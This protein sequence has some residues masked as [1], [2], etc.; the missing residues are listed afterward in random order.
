MQT[1]TLFPPILL[2]LNFDQ[3]PSLF[4]R[5]VLLS[6]VLL[7]Y[8]L[9][10]R[11]DDNITSRIKFWR[12]NVRR[13]INI[14]Q[15][16][17]RFHALHRTANGETLV[18]LQSL[19]ASLDHLLLIELPLI[20]G[21]LLI[22]SVAASITDRDKLSV[23]EL[24]RGAQKSFSNL[25]YG[26]IFLRH[27]LLAIHVQRI[28]SREITLHLLLLRILVK[29]SRWWASC[30]SCFKICDRGRKI[31]PFCGLILPK[32]PPTLIVHHWADR[33]EYVTFALL[34]F[35]GCL[36]QMSI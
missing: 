18:I 32:I 13:S 30:L 27:A 15:R 11:N 35:W 19:W 16:R 23:C 26:L 24:G 8:L 1:L 2:F 20:G 33:V 5:K 21:N 28:V 9:I 22:V 12:L 36:R 17:I 14:F 31:D 6:T 29:S 3:I 34:L 25:N 7:K 4:S 10:V